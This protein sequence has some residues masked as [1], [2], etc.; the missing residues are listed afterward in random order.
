MLYENNINVTDMHSIIDVS[1][2]FN[3]MAIVDF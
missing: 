3:L 2:H 1:I